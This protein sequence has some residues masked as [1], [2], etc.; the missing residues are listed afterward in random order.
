MII[1]CLGVSAQSE[2]RLDTVLVLDNI[3]KTEIFKRSKLWFFGQVREDGQS[4][5]Q[6][7]DKEDGILFGR[8]SHALLVSNTASQW[9]NKL[10]WVPYVG[11]RAKKINDVSSWAGLSGDLT[12]TI[13]IRMKEG[14]CKVSMTHINHKS[15]ADAEQS[16][17]SMGVI[18]G[19]VPAHLGVLKQ[20]QYD[21]L[22][23]FALPTVEKWWDDIISSLTLSLNEESQ[24]DNW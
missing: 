7:E 14:K 6:Y 17:M 24:D 4:S 10:S 1:S 5:L 11:K 8:V 23:N 3:S 16:D 18:Y 19:D 13:E 20:K 15:K 2:L 12:A 9:V 21:V 22:L